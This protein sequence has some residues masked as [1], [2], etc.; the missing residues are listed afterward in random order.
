MI[1]SRDAALSQNRQQA[2]NI[3]FH[4]D[5]SR[6]SAGRLLVFVAAPRPE[7]SLLPRPTIIVVAI[8]VRRHVAQESRSCLFSIPPGVAATTVSTNCLCELLTIPLDVDILAQMKWQQEHPQHNARMLAAAQH[9]VQ[10]QYQQRQQGEQNIQRHIDEGLHQQHFSQ[11]QQCLQ[12]QHQPQ[13]QPQHRHQQHNQQHEHQGQ[14]QNVPSYTIPDG[15]VE[16]RQPVLFP[17]VQPQLDG[18]VYQQLTAQQPSR[19]AYAPPYQ[20][21]DAATTCDRVPPRPAVSS[22]HD[23]DKNSLTRTL[24]TRLANGEPLPKKR[25]K[26]AGESGRVH[27]YT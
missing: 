10:L 17:T 2:T 4:P 18:Y 13:Q 15:A 12:P 9:R 6:E 5:V 8:G 23:Q 14:Q 27:G 11:Q 16:E 7:S 22:P 25:K 19:S 21:D 26:K 24:G 20:S 1:R 3:G